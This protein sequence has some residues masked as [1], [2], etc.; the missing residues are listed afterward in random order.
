MTGREAVGSMVLALAL[1]LSAAITK[2]QSDSKYPD[3]KGQWVRIGGGQYDPSKPGGVRQ[4]PPLTPEYKAVWE[5]NIAAEAKGSQEYNPQARCL[6]GGMPRMMIAYEP[7]EI[8]VTPETT[9]I[10]VE[11]MGEFRRIYT[12][13]RSWPQHPTPE[14]RGTSIGRWIDAGG[15]GRF[16]TLM[17]ETRYL[18]GPRTF[19]ADGM[20][21][22]ADSQTIVKEHIY[23][24]R[25]DANLLRDDVTTSSATA[26]EMSPRRNRLIAT[27]ASS[28]RTK[29]GAITLVS[30][31]SAPGRRPSPAR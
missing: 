11:Q 8:I 17:V 30:R 2:A 22:H 12:D 26:R 15:A 25:A 9:Y 28:A 10:W 5:D 24:D 1:C 18:K 4:A 14:F 27:F 16:D 3:W 19:D 23:L 29:S 7:M 6:P 20:P 21:L 13:G 31:R